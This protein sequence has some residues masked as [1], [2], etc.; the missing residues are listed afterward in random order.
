MNN[1]FRTII[2]AWAGKKWG[3]GCLGFIAVFVI[4]YFL[5]GKVHC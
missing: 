4:V 2:A 5:L 1:F 3:G